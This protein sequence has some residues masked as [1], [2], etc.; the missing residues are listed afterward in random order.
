MLRTNDLI[1]KSEYN[2][3]VKKTIIFF[4]KT[5]FILSFISTLY[6][7]IDYLNVFENFFIMTYRA[8]LLLDLFIPI[9]TFAV[10]IYVLILILKYKIKNTFKCF[11]L[12][13]F[14]FLLEIITGFIFTFYFISRQ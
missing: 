13:I 8:I 7:S 11:M 5:N 10:L 1:V 6:F 3:K 9:F 2:I 4:T 12:A 14:S